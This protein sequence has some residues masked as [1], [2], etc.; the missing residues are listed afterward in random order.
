MVIDTSALITILF[1]EPDADYFETALESDSTR[2]MSTA[3]VLEAAIVVEARLGEAG[4]RELDLLLHKAQIMSIAFSA[5][6]VE[7][8]RHAFRTFGKRRHPAGL[9]YGDCFSYALS[10]TSG[11]A[12][13]FKGNDFARTDVEQWKPMK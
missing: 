6:Q 12:L 13:L 4:G 7:M 11:Q 2:L 10:K 9:N 3:S 1:D 5:E 8:A